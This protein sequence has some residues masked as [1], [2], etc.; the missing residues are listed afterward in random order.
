MKKL[1]LGALLSIIIT[2]LVLIIGLASIF[3]IKQNEAGHVT[4]DTDYMAYAKIYEEDENYTSAASAYLKVVEEDENNEEALHGLAKAYN[5]LNSYEDAEY[6]YGMI[7]DRGI[8]SEEEILFYVNALIQNE[9]LDKAKDII[10]TVY[11]ENASDEV[12]NYYEQMHIDSPQFNY[13]SGSYDEY[14]LLEVI[15]ASEIAVIH[16]T[17]NGDEPTKDSDIFSDDGIVISAPENT[18]KLKSIGYLGYESDT[19]ELDIDITVPV[20]DIN[21]RRYDSLLYT[22]A[23]KMNN[24]SDHTIKNYQLAQVR[25]IY[26][27]GSDTNIEKAENYEFYNG[28]YK[29]YSS[30]MD[31]RGNYDLEGLEYFPFLKEL[32]FCYQEDIDL[33]PLAGHKYLES[34]SLMNDSITDIS[35]LSGL[36]GLKRLN[37]GWNDVNDI[38]ALK[39]LNLVSLGLWNN[40]ITDIGAVAGMNELQYLDITN[41]YVTDISPIR[42]LDALNELWMSGNSVSDISATESCPHLN[43][44]YHDE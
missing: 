19:V 29:H 42:G 20:E 25:N 28:R 18:I 23:R 31:H 43:V 5:E 35:A 40:N 3:V 1:K 39:G 2:I 41:N 26:I 27:I 15:E 36:S 6:V 12:R 4:E 22:V 32:V 21:T 8:A 9:K 34:L 33:S 37:L 44:V 11:S 7:Y 14:L 13:S 10:D 30:M 16:Y 38:S 24:Y 17:T